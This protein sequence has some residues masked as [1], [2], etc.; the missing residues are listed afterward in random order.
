[1]AVMMPASAGGCCVSVDQLDADLNPSIPCGTHLDPDTTAPS[2]A[3]VAN[4]GR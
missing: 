1:M 3:A 4:Q 2:I